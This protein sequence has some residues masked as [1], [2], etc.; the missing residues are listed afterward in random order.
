MQLLGPANEQTEAYGLNNARQ[1]VG[2]YPQG[3]GAFLSQLVNGKRRLLVI[4]EGIATGINNSGQ[5]VVNR[6]A[7]GPYLFTITGANGSGIRT[8]LTGGGEALAI[9]EAAQVAGGMPVTLVLAGDGV[10]QWKTTPAAL[11]LPAAAHGLNA[12]WNNLGHPSSPV[13]Q[14]EWLVSVA[15]ALN[16]VGM[17]VGTS[18]AYDLAAPGPSYP[19]TARTVGL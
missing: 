12:G 19:A 8:E 10:T 7:N 5:V 4:G 3:D 17:A 13:A 9:N 6:G 16:N 18:S 1:V 2:W 14:G 15:Q 11:Y